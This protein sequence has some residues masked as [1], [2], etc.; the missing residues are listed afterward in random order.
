M[1]FLL[2]CLGW[3]FLRYVHQMREAVLNGCHSSEGA[4]HRR[5]LEAR[6]CSPLQRECNSKIGCVILM[7]DRGSLGRRCTNLASE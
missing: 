1:S 2:I 3:S 6:D 4:F 5:V 7:F